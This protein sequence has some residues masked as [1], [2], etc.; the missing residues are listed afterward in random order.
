MIQRNSGTANTFLQLV[1]VV[2]CST[3]QGE[4]HIHTSMTISER[5][6]RVQHLGRVVTSNTLVLVSYKVSHLWNFNL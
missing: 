1:C 3:Q 5:D 4:V 2:L 6:N